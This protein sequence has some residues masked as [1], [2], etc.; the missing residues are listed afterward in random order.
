MNTLGRRLVGTRHN[1]LHV[2]PDDLGALGLTDDDL[3]DI[4]SDHGRIRGVVASDSSARPGVVSMTHCYGA[5]PGQDE[6]PRKYGANPA[7]LLSHTDGRQTINAMPRMTAVPV[8]L[9]P[10]QPS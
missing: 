10:A 4:E 9:R 2:H 7:R 6:D 8:S 3:V 1:P 5:L